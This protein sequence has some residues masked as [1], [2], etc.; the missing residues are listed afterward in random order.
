MNRMTDQRFAAANL[1]AEPA[2]GN[3]ARDRRHARRKQDQR[4]LP[5]GQVPI[6]DEEREHKADQEE[7][8]EIQHAGQ[9]RSGEDLP[10]VGGE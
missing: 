2:A 7:I 9:N 10:L 6:L 1:V 3:A 8:E 5:I 4:R